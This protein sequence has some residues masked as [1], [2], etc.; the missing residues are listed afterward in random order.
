[1]AHNIHDYPLMYST[2]IFQIVRTE[3]NLHAPVLLNVC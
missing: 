3:I 2:K 1:M